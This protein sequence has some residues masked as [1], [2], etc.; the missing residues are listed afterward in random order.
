[1]ICVARAYPRLEYVNTFKAKYGNVVIPSNSLKP[2]AR[3]SLSV[4]TDIKLDTLHRLASYLH[5]NFYDINVDKVIYSYVVA[6][7]ILFSDKKSFNPDN[8]IVQRGKAIL[9]REYVNYLYTLKSYIEANKTKKKYT[10]LEKSKISASAV[11]SSI[12]YFR[13]K[14]E[15]RYKI[16]D[17]V[18]K[19][20]GEPLRNVWANLP[21]WY[22]ITA[23]L[24][25]I[26]RYEKLNDYVGSTILANDILSGEERESILAWYQKAG[27]PS[28]IYVDMYE[29]IV[30]SAFNLKIINTIIADTGSVLLSDLLKRTVVFS[31][32]ALSEL[33]VS[34]KLKLVG[35]FID[36]SILS[37]LGFNI[38]VEWQIDGYIQEVLEPIRRQ[39]WKAILGFVPSSEGMGDDR[40]RIYLYLYHYLKNKEISKFDIND[41]DFLL[42]WNKLSEKQR[43]A[44]L[45]VIKR[46]KRYE[47]LKVLR[48]EFRTKATIVSDVANYYTREAYKV[49]KDFIGNTPY[50]VFGDKVLF[51][52]IPIKSMVDAFV[53]NTS[54]F[55]VDA[56]NAKAELEYQRCLQTPNSVCYKKTYSYRT[57][58]NPYLTDYTKSVSSDLSPI[59]IT[60]NMFQP[61][62]TNLRVSKKFVDISYQAKK[63]NEIIMSY[64]NIE[65]INTTVSAN[66]SFSYIQSAEL[67][68]NANDIQT[69]ILSCLTNVSFMNRNTNID[70]KSLFTPLYSIEYKDG[71]PK[72]VRQKYSYNDTVSV[73][74]GTVS[75]PYQSQSYLRTDFE[76]EYRIRASTLSDMP[77]YATY[78][79]YHPIFYFCRTY[80]NI[81]SITL[82]VDDLY[83]RNAMNI[84]KAISKTISYKKATY[85]TEDDYKIILSPSTLISRIKT[86]QPKLFNDMITGRLSEYKIRKILMDKYKI[87]TKEFNEYVIEYMAKYLDKYEEYLR[88]LMGKIV[89]G[90]YVKIRFVSDT[91][92]KRDYKIPLVNFISIIPEHR[93]YVYNSK[94]FIYNSDYPDVS[95]PYYPNRRVVDRKTHNEWLSITI[96]EKG[97]VYG[98]LYPVYYYDSALRKYVIKFR[99]SVYVGYYFNYSKMHS[100]IS[101]Y[102]NK[103]IRIDKM[104]T[105]TIDGYNS[106]PTMELAFYPKPF[107]IQ[108]YLNPYNPSNYETK[109]KKT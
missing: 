11:L 79:R 71:V 94:S 23:M 106:P 30:E 62:Q 90:Y 36:K 104:A 51:D 5:S 96:N 33:F 21:L 4:N 72:I 84:D 2:I 47:E 55:L 53:D 12:E 16:Y 57:A 48:K 52:E 42:K 58:N 45:S 91:G 66:A 44:I 56:L 69:G 73:Y 103:S 43:I 13:Y 7:S 25:I 108:D 10:E 24:D 40:N 68:I 28:S 102:D 46:L 63:T 98:I 99:Y 34:S 67:S 14:P 3:N 77:M 64:N 37:F 87:T 85:L 70:Y 93:C 83:K 27:R 107:S 61:Y 105:F 81:E 50:V 29:D 35:Q 54:I 59:R 39:V 100:D 76:A 74:Y 86:E 75:I 20:I 95:S 82:E 32:Y 109:C 6:R 92:V 101:K 9:G 22:G 17:D 88:R 49:I 31:L 89:K 8:E 26:D 97:S 60:A 1:M 19:K 65:G 38:F 15:D 80:G 41:S 18:E 78:Y